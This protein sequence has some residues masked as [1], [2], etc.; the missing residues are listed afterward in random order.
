MITR[1]ACLKLDA[2]DDLRDY[3]RRFVLP[4]D[5]IYLNGNSLGPMPHGVQTTVAWNM[6]IGWGQDLVTSWSKHKWFELPLLLGERLGRLIG[7]GTGNTVV[8]DTV[9]VN[10]F[11]VLTAALAKN[12]S[13]KVILSDLG[14]F[15]SDLYVAQGLLQF[16]GSGYELRCVAPEDVASAL[17]DEI[18]VVML[19]DVD[20]RTARRHDMQS[21]TAQA[22][23]KGCLTIWDLSHSVGAVPIDVLASGAD[24]AVGCTY[25][26]VNG[27]PGAP[28][29]VFVL[30]RH[31]GDA[32]P[33][34]VGWWGHAQPF[35]FDTQ[36]MPAPGLARFQCGTQPMLSVVAL[37]AALS[38]WDHV[39]MAKL[40][41][42]SQGL[43]QLF[44]TCVEEQCAGFG[45]VLAGPRD[46]AERGSHVSFHCPDGYAVMQAMIAQNVIGDFRAPDLIRFGFAPLFNTFTEVFDAAAT[47]HRI[48]RDKLWQRPEFMTRKNVT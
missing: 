24:Y 16:L 42:K 46:M 29:F 43:C 4:K 22:H 32:A 5:V 20:Y 23:A 9:T 19:T 33:A 12:P 15:P 44:I 28:G 41:A 39:D 35:A 34:L 2:E 30:P 14:N 3:R 40:R 21:I 18:A 1:D 26:Y 37:E 17:T 45:L 13:R 38:V 8:G 25:K 6:D 48:M 31:H 7:A 27:G 47:L 10:L 36:W 11:K